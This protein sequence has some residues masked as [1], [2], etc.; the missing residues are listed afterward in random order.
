M[1]KKILSLL[2]AVIV[3]LIIAA[4][5]SIVRSGEAGISLHPE[6]PVE[7]VA[8]LVDRLLQGTLLQYQAGKAY[9][10]LAETLPFH[11]LT[12]LHYIAIASSLSILLG[13]GLG[14]LTSF[15]QGRGFAAVIELLHI[16]PDFILAILLQLLVITVTQ[17]TGV[18]IARTAYVSSS[19]PAYLL[20]ITVMTIVA[21]VFVL[22]SVHGYLR[23]IKAQDYILY[24]M[25]KG[26]AMPRLVTT[27]L[28]VPV[29]HRLRGDLHG[30]L[31]LLIGNLFIIERIFHIPGVTSFL[32]HNAFQRI[33]GSFSSGN[34]NVLTQYHV[35]LSGLL[36]IVL[37]Y[38]LLYGLFSLMLTLIIRWREQ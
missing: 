23:E 28:L 13:L 33:P 38:W 25:T 21:A 37:I 24:A 22:R 19:M 34:I 31:A 2:I 18:R 36:S 11:L 8:D 10:S 29:L 12:S 15:R 17:T 14:F 6:A 35:A 32:F 4:G 27:H 7:A 3:F 16:V 9:H 1:H 26:L 5:P 20:P 30:V